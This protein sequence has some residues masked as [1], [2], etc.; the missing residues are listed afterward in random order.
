MLLGVEHSA[1]HTG[2]VRAKSKFE[3]QNGVLFGFH[4]LRT[5]ARTIL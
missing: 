1:R 5:F 3:N 2:S 4:E